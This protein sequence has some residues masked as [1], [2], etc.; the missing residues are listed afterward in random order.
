[1]TWEQRAQPVVIACGAGKFCSSRRGSEAAPTTRLLREVWRHFLVV[2]VDEHRTSSFHYGTTARLHDIRR[3]RD[4]RKVRGVPWCYAANAPGSNLFIHWDANASMNIRWCLLSGADPPLH[5]CGSS[6]DGALPPQHSTS[7]THSMAAMW[8]SLV[9][10]QSTQPI[11]AAGRSVGPGD[12][13]PV[14]WSANEGVAGQGKP[15]GQTG[16]QTPC[17]PR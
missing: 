16:C 8:S 11:G 17:P 15:A 2:M 4:S 3:R 13:W 12:V 5:L 10:D 9:S 6:G 14:Q 7:I 1:V